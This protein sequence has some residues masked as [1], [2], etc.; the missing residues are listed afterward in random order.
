MLFKT[1]NKAVKQAPFATKVNPTIILSI[2]S[3]LLFGLCLDA[4]PIYHDL[5]KLTPIE[6]PRWSFD[7]S[8]IIDVRENQDEIG[9]IYQGSDRA[10]VKT[11]LQNDLAEDLERL[12]WPLSSDPSRQAFIMRVNHLAYYEL[13]YYGRAVA[14]TELNVSFLNSKDSGF[15]EIFQATVTYGELGLDGTEWFGHVIQKVLEQCLDDL[16][17]HKTSEE[18]ILKPLKSI[19][20]NP[21]HKRVF[22][23]QNAEN[24]TKCLY[25][26]FYDFRDDKRDTSIVFYPNLIYDN[27]EKMIG[28]RID[29][30][31]RDIAVQDIY[32]FS[33]GK[34]LFLRAGSS[35]IKLTDTLGHY[36]LKSLPLKN[37]FYQEDALAP[38]NYQGIRKMSL[39]NLIT[40][41]GDVE[42]WTID[43]DKGQVVPNQFAS[44]SLK[45][46]YAVIYGSQFNKK[47][48]IAKL[49]VNEEYI[50]D[51]GPNQY[52]II[53]GSE[54]DYMYDVCLEYDGVKNCRL[55]KTKSRI[56]GIYYAKFGGKNR[57]EIKFA[58]K[59]EGEI[60]NNAIES[61]HA[62]RVP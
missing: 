52:Y 42:Y 9:Y 45:K 21:Y 40:P 23:I 53:E 18:G 24:L 59:E 60:L 46:P 54:D 30:I 3:S 35:F 44:F 7:L 11:L 15:V 6:N 43:F 12:L 39:H 27:K 47:S 37:Q 61:K 8:A 34:D 33:D 62:K 26:N 1:S 20:Q 10:Q 2:L 48:S 4:Q 58:T 25:R 51:L 36:I 56:S 29:L 50:T 19:Y 57:I 14:I 13:I 41:L 49:Y 28:S 5:S 38:W 55:L 16:E 17:A 31:N 32:A 22:P